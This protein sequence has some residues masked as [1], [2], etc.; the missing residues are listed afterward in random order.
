[1]SGT[2]RS[3]PIQ[4]MSFVLTESRVFSISSIWFTLVAEGVTEQIMMSGFGQK[5][6]EFITRVHTDSDG[7]RLVC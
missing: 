1:M 6:W 2:F 7:S 5:L 3:P 4:T